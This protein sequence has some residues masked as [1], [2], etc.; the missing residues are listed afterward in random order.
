MQRIVDRA[1]RYLALTT[2]IEIGPR[3]GGS[4]QALLLNARWTPDGQSP[5]SIGCLPPPLRMKFA[6][7]PSVEIME[8][9]ILKVESRAR[10][11]GE[12]PGPSFA[13]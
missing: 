2:V 1:W 11:V 3:P 6:R 7:M 12:R 10:C 5:N 8:A 13:I 9:D 4:L